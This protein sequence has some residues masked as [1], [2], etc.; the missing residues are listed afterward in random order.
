MADGEKIIRIDIEEEMKTAYIDYSMS[1]IVSRALPDVRDGLKPVHRRVLYGMLDLG[2]MSNKPHKKS[3][4][5]VGEVLGKYHPH[6]DT[7]V[8]DAMVRMAQD[9]SLRYP[10]VD[11]QG[12][13]GSVDGDSP[14]AMR[15][16]EARLKKIAEE[17]LND[18]EKDTVDF[19]PNFDDSL[20]E[21]TV[22]P[23]RIP[24]LLINGASGIAV[25]MATNMPPHNLTEIVNATM[26]YIDNR[27]I[28]VA[29][30]MQHVKA[31]DFPTGGII[32]G[33]EGVKDA[34]ET[35]R[36]RIIMR[37]QTNVEIADNGRERIIVNAIPYQIN[38]A[39][40]IRKTADLIN[41]KKIE[42]I[43]DIRDESDRDG[44]RIVYE[45]K[46]DAITNVVLN[47]LF[48][49]TE[50]QTSFSV[51]NIALVGGR[52]M[53]LNLKDMIVHFVA[54]RHDVVV[55]RTKFEL[56]QAEKRAH[57]LEGY[58]I[59]LDH[60]DEVIKLIR[61]SSTPSEAQDGLMSNFG[62]SE[63]QSK[64]ILEMRLR[65]LTGL[66]RDKIKAE[67][68]ELMKLIDHLRLVL[69]DEGLRMKIIK[70]ELIEI[71]DKYGDVRKTEIVYASGDFKIEDMIANEEVVITISHMG[72]IKRTLL[73]EY[74]TQ[75]RGG[76]G[77]KGSTTRDEDFIEHLFIASTHNYLLLFTEQ[78]RCFWMRAFEV[79]EGTRQSKGRAIQNLINI[80]P[81]DKVKA[82]INV[83]NLMDEEYTKNNFIIMCT[84]NGIIKKTTLEAYSRPRQN[85]I[86]A[87]TVREG[88]ALLEVLLTNGTNEIM[89]ASKAGKVVRFNEANVR[90]MGRNASGVRG[91]NIGDEKGNEVIGM[92]AMPDQLS[93]VMVVSEKGYG[94][95]SDIEEY[96]VTKR[97]GKGVKTINITEKTGNLIAIKDVTDKDGLMIINKSGIIIRLAVAELR[98]IGRA[99]Q[100]VRLINLKATDEI[101]AVSKVD[102]EEVIEEVAGAESGTE[103]DGTEG[104][105]ET[106]ASEDTEPGTDVKDVE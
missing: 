44:M 4:R 86:N 30:L 77:A 37:A 72:Y 5:I 83:K 89:L 52:P 29:G 100:G 14:A 47:N 68:E 96:R 102:M 71:R 19:R 63:L 99:T 51:N 92:I 84:R 1:V 88:D 104:S 16:T 48:K 17:M 8:Y 78:G 21:P 75:A 9:W 95:R 90:P 103:A 6:G 76:K 33:Y 81:T 50:L 93:N 74:R 79:P 32:Y 91:I 56:V 2:V 87:I 69:N 59:A 55:R 43:S 49:Y 23:T 46:R 62:L 7:S 105:S 98:V 67:Y 20:T 28:D 54:H 57:I 85:G 61:A 106:G 34:F 73:S 11:G 13:Y 38:K 12:N 82:Y 15:Y 10:L 40:M 22:L 24:N 35:G 18:I 27:D 39:E 97:G 25:G 3:A 53:M 45:I 58:L 66:E 101:A 70:D 60:L 41:D 36:G 65:V 94:K 80:P 64:A 42:G 26:A 31:P